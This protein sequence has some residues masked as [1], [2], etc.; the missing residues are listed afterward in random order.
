MTLS[1][2]QEKAVDE[3]LD[4]LLDN[5]KEE[6]VISGSAGTGKTF[7]MKYLLDITRSQK[8]LYKLLLDSVDE[9]SVH[10]TSTT[11]KAARALYEATGEEVRTIHSLLGIRPVRDYKTGME[12]FKRSKDSTVIQNYLI[13]VDEASMINNHLLKIIRESTY[14][15]KILYIGDPYQLAPVFLNECPVFKSVATR[16]H[17]TE[18]Q[19]QVSG[20]PI[21]TL[22]NK[23]KDAVDTSVFPEIEPVPGIIDVVDGPELQTYVDKHFY[24]KYD[25]DDMRIL[26]WTNKKVH[27]YNN[28][29]RN[30]GTT[31]LAYEVGE[32][33][34][35]NEA[36][37]NP[38]DETIMF[39][40]DTFVQVT[41]V[42]PEETV[43]MIEGYYVRLNGSDK[44]FVPFVQQ[45]VKT[46]LKHLATHKDWKAYYALKDFC[47]DIR[48][49]HSNSVHKSQGSTYRTAIIDLDDIGRNTKNY[50]IAR[51]MYVA[52][53]RASTNVI[54]KGNLP[55]RLYR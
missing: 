1:N 48:P 31:S 37:I 19:R 8:K 21:I 54:L 13:I 14:N 9:L 7:L 27:A 30:K 6:M 40:A 34:V 3:F 33:L 46:M 5:K 18:I 26:A 11:H 16:V 44:L 4:F 15:C 17:L 42:Y 45:N 36:V 29:V 47:I 10:L 12:V 41:Q 28:Y 24:G 35:T 32:V 43:H 49:I 2:E 53:S 50:E 51:L 20:S 22:F 23:F 55:D 52:I 25:N 39:K 38:H